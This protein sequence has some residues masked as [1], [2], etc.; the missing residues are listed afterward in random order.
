MGGHWY[1]N[2][3]KPMHWI[4]GANGKQRDTTLRDARK[5]NLFPSVTTILG[6]I[7][8]PAL[9]KWKL[10]Q[11]T[12][13]C[14]N[15][16]DTEAHSL[17]DDYHKA[18][19]GEAFKPSTDARDR[20][21]EIHDCLEALILDESRD[22]FDD[23][24]KD[25]ARVALLDVLRYCGAHRQDF[26][27]EAT[28]VGDGY[29]GMIDLH[30]DEFLIDWKTK[31]ID[32]IKKKM[33]YPEQAMQLAAYDHALEDWDGMPL[34][35]RRCINVFIDR[36]EPGKLVIYEWKPEDISL[37]WQK[38]QLLVKYWQLDKGYVPNIN[39]EEA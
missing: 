18:M 21:S 4:E 6:T 37:A 2:E 24:I 31:D 10:K 8:K 35:G 19:M 25:I 27:P 11:V 38:F 16:S 23:D 5:L 26:T 28:V 13:A 32:D 39:E 14:Y 15:A 1:T 30:N 29:G 33:A 7:D 36:Q 9:T 17:Y 12:G 22:A 3:G 34:S 20:G